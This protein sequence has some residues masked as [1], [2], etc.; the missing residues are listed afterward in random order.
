MILDD[1]F[2]LRTPRKKKNRPDENTRRMI[3]DYFREITAA[4]RNTIMARLPDN[5]PLWGK[6]RMASGGDCVRT[7]MAIN[8]KRPGRD[9]SFVRV[10][11]LNYGYS[12]LSHLNTSKIVRANCPRLT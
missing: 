3:T 10:S 1:N 2:V 8:S 6:F 9:M 5:M 4:N 12:I 7:A 11:E